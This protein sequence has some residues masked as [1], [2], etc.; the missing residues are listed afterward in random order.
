MHAQT[1]QVYHLE[2]VHR[3]LAAHPMESLGAPTQIL[4]RRIILIRNRNLVKIC[5]T[6]SSQIQF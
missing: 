1:P 5:Q 2:E 6:M 3:V 4:A